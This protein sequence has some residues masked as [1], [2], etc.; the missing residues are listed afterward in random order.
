MRACGEALSFEAGANARHGFNGF[1]CGLVNSLRSSAFAAAQNFFRDFFYGQKYRAMHCFNANIYDPTSA[2]IQP[3]ASSHY[4]CK[5]RKV[6]KNIGPFD[7][8]S[9][10]SSVERIIQLGL[11]QNRK[12]AVL[13]EFM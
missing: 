4:N 9:N 2:V 8:R 5:L 7:A 1:I 6:N 11:D 12:R 13:F 3:R 10:R